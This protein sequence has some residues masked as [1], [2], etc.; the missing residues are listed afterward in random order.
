VQYNTT[1]YK[2]QLKIKLHEV[3]GLPGI[4][5]LICRPRSLQTN[6]GTITITI[7]IT[8]NTAETTDYVLLTDI[9]MALDYLKKLL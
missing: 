1:I 7:T 5:R 3:L 6:T 2:I 8:C 9:R 4:F